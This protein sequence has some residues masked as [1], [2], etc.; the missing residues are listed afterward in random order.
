MGLAE[1][2]TGTIKLVESGVNSV[3]LMW[4]DDNWTMIENVEEECI[5]EPGDLG[6]GVFISPKR[7]HKFYDGEDAIYKNR[8]RVVVE[9][10]SVIIYVGDKCP[11]SIYDEV[12]KRFKL[13]SR[14]YKILIRHN[15]HWDRVERPK[16]YKLNL[17]A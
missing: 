6:I 11:N 10:N 14:S 9:G 2:I 8:G 13:D 17:W 15:A 4:F 5:F 1:T 7:G 3:G 16:R 12:I